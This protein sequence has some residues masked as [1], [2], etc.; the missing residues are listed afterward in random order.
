[1]IIKFKNPPQL[2]K[3]N[4][5]YEY[6][7]SESK[8]NVEGLA[9][10]IL[11]IE[12]TILEDR[13]G[14]ASSQWDKLMNQRQG[15]KKASIPRT[16]M[17]AQFNLF[18][19]DDTK[20]LKEL[21]KR[22]VQLFTMDDCDLWGQCWANVLRNGEAF[23]PHMHCISTQAYLS[24]N[25]AVQTSETSTHYMTPYF[26]E[27]Y[28]SKNEDGNMTLFPSWLKHYT[29][30]AKCG[31]ERITIGFD[32]IPVESYENVLAEKKSHWEKL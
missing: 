10:T 25:V 15:M 3:F 20:F 6:D 23:P 24:G 11:K 14:L 2:H 16:N 17:F 5:V 19:L 1:M 12:K 28:E 29:D 4:P 7:I 13:Q 26:E 27:I 22:E 31:Q 21:V 18:Q 30:S 32:V 9:D 8:I